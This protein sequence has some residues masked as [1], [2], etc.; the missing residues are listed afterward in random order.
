MPDH[1]YEAAA[2]D[3]AN[4]WHRFWAVTLPLITPSLF[5]NMV[6]ALIGAFQVF[7]QA[8]VMTRGG[9]QNATLFYILYL[10][11]SAFEDFKMGYA[12]ALAWILFLIILAFTLVQFWV[13]GRWVYYEVDAKK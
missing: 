9:P 2:I 5:F 10:Y 12:S 3:G 6:V 11:R 13:A 1:L 4:A 7:T 8:Y